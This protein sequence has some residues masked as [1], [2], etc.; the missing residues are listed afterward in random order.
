MIDSFSFLDS[1]KVAAPIIGI[2]IAV[3]IKALGDFIES[4]TARKR[5]LEAEKQ[6][7]KSGPEAFVKKTEELKESQASLEQQARAI[8]ALLQTAQNALRVGTL[9]DL[10]SKQIEKYQT[11]TQ[12]RAGWS[13]IFAII[14]MFSGLGFVVWGG[15]HILADSGWG[16]VA[17]GSGISAIGGAISAYITKTFLDVHKLSLNQLNHYF[18]Q[19]VINAH[20]LTAQRL[21]DELSNDA[22][23]QKAYETILHNVVALIRE[24]AQLH[25]D[26]VDTVSATKPS[27]TRRSTKSP[28]TAKKGNGSAAVLHEG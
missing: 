25:S 15:T 24:D 8:S 26:G 6:A 28:S 22:A 9:F 12:A 17:A 16:H 14:A 21:A 27:A 19:P 4:R 7:F 18:R 5:M 23:R 13:F 3:F 10:Y 1:F 20:V 11:E 2:G